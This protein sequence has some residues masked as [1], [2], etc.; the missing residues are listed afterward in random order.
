MT[1]EDIIKKLE[2]DCKG[3]TIRRRKKI[4]P[5]TNQIWAEI[6]INKLLKWIKSNLGE[7]E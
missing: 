2:E 5:Y 4:V 3:I 1:I 6:Y 7:D